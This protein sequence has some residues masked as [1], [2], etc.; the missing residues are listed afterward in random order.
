MGKSRGSFSLWLFV[1]LC[2][3][4]LFSSLTCGMEREAS[5]AAGLAAVVGFRKGVVPGPFCSLAGFQG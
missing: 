2:K 4:T 1:F 5:E 3:I